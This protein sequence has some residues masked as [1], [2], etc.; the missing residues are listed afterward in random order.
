M[1]FVPLVYLFTTSSSVHRILTLVENSISGTCR[2]QIRTML[3][4]SISR[5]GGV[6]LAITSFKER[7]SMA[8]RLFI[9]SMANGMSHALLLR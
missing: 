4:W 6:S 9:S 7:F 5:E 3:S 1:R 2:L 8:Q